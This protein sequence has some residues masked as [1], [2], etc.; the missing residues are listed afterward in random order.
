[1]TANKCSHFQQS[2]HNGSFFTHVFTYL[3]T[4]YLN[5]ILLVPFS[6]I[7]V[8]TFYSKAEMFGRERVRLRLRM[9]DGLVF[10][11]RTRTPN[12]RIRTSLQ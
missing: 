8:C 6:G 12:F 10:Q 5:I 7:S 9:R 2:M 3:L 4:F 1:M 11:T